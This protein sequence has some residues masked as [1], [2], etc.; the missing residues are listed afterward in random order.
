M[1]FQSTPVG[2]S[3][4]G[5]LPPNPAVCLRIGVWDKTG[6]AQQT[7]RPPKARSFIFV[8]GSKNGRLQVADILA[9]GVNSPFRPL[10]AYFEEGIVASDF[11]PARF[12]RSEVVCCDHDWKIVAGG[13]GIESSCT[14]FQ[15]FLKERFQLLKR[16]DIHLIVEV[17]MAGTGDNE[18][19]LVV[20]SQLAVRGF[21]E[22]A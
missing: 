22:I 8:P 13:L 19:F 21:A 11:I 10:F 16:N 1:P 18:Q 3:A 20:P 2:S 15:I 4:L 9:E 5:V 14:L 6:T 12:R 17:G 7:I